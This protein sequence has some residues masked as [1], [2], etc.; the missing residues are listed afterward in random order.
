MAEKTLLLKTV[1]KAICKCF[2][3]ISGSKN[4]GIIFDLDTHRFVLE[5]EKADGSSRKFA[6]DEISDVYKNTLCM[7]GDIA[8]RM[9]V[10][11]PMLGDKVLEET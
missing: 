9:A 5:Y 11:N 4:A 3:R 1:E 6:M 2:E 10:L 8:Y 7:I